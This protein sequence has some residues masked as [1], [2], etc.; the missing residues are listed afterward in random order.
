MMQANSTM[1]VPRFAS[2]TPAA[3]IAALTDALRSECRLLKELLAVMQG[4]REAVARDD[5]EAVEDSVYATH[6]ILHTLNEARRRRRSINRL[7]G[8][9]D[10]LS[11][12]G[13]ERVL[14]T[15]MPDVLRDAR[16][17]LELLA[18]ALTTEVDINRRVLRQALA[19]GD[20]YVRTLCGTLEPK[21]GYSKR[22]MRE[23]ERAGG[24]LVDRIA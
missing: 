9:S 23:P 17:E 16:D 1:T 8:E 6:R 21:V 11:I 13:L 10:D 2:E 22:S 24:L 5:L 12:Q 3:T 15:R 7:L 18:R 20:D 4:Q 14:G 19:S